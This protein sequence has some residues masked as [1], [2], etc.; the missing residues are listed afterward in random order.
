VE[1]TYSPHSSHL[2]SKMGVAASLLSYSLPPLLI[3]VVVTKGLGELGFEPANKPDD[4][5]RQN[6]QWRGSDEA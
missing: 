1:I 6:L 4:C 3:I 2:Q 5:K